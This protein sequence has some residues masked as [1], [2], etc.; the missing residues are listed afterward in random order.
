MLDASDAA[1]A[2]EMPD[3]DLRGV[4]RMIDGDT[5]DVGPVRV[6]LHGID[7]PEQDQRCGGPDGR[8]WACG[9]WVTT[10]TQALFDGRDAACT[11]LER[12]RYDRVIAQCTI[13]GRDMGA[14]L[15]SRG[16]AFA[17]RRYSTRYVAAERAARAAQTGLHGSAIVA[18]EQHRATRITRERDSAGQQHAQGGKPGGVCVIKGNIGRSGARIYHRPGQEWYARTRIDPAKGE[19]LF[20]SEDEARAAGW[21]PAQR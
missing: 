20:C 18:P 5:L 13:G 12:D 14:L 17:Y 2:T 8:R 21:R 11:A 4:V 15:V 3:A 7:A 16:L 9:A 19:R 10:Q 1:G 6:R